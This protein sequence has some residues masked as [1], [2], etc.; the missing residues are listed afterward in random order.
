MLHFGK[1]PENFDQ[2][3]AQIQQKN[4]DKLAKFCLKNQQHVQ[5]F[6]TKKLRFANGAQECV[7]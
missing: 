5:Q 2:N 1:N 4:S 3:F 7:M 6:L